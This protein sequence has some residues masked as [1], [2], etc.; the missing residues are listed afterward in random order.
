MDTIRLTIMVVT[1]D[2]DMPT[3]AALV[4]VAEPEFQNVQEFVSIWGRVR[5]DTEEIGGK[6]LDT[7]ALLGQHDFLVV[8]EAPDIEAAFQV[9]IAAE[10]Y[11]IDVETMVA[12]PVEQ[13]GKLVEEV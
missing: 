4:D 10:R 13:L 3:F 11:G 5:K 1:Y 6:V 9:S 8:Y 7:Y 12:E 2:L